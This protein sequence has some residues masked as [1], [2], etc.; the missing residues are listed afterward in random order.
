MTVETRLDQVERRVTRLDTDRDSHADK[1]DR[2][3]Q[4]IVD[5]HDDVRMLN[6]KFDKQQAS[7]PDIIA[8]A[9]A[10]LLVRRDDE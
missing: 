9:V 1:F 6:A 7:L 10:P 2:V 3:L 4:A 5:L 8:R